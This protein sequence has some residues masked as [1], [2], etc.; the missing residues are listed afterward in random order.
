MGRE[1]IFEVEKTVLTDNKTFKNQIKNKNTN[2]ISKRNCKI[3][4]RN[5]KI[6]VFQKTRKNYLPYHI[7]FQREVY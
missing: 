5:C 4:V 6:T 3:T 1:E 2:Q 7:C